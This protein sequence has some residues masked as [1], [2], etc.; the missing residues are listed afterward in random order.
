MSDGRV[1]LNIEGLDVPDEFVLLVSNGGNVQEGAY[2]V[3]WR[4]GN[5]LVSGDW[6]S[7]NAILL[8]Q[9]P[10]VIRTNC[11]RVLVVD[12]VSKAHELGSSVTFAG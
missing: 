12:P 3:V 4:F 10:F 8:G 2:K 11:R 7:P 1:R 5:E 9:D 6:A